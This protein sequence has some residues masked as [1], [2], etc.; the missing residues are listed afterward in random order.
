[1][2]LRPAIF[3]LAVLTH[4]PINIRH[5]YRQQ[6][7][8]TGCSETRVQILNGSQNLTNESNGLIFVLNCRE[9]ITFYNT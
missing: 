2:M 8:D 6:A 5:L 1:M 4:S 7:Q 3:R 9:I